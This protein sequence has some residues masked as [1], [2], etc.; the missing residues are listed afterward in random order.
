[1][2]TPDPALDDAPELKQLYQD[3]EAEHLNPL[4]TQLGDLMPMTPT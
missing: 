3:F 4:W 1:M 2:H